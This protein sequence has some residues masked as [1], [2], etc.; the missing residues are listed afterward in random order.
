MSKHKGQRP[1]FNPPLPA[2]PSQPS[3]QTYETLP[4]GAVLVGDPGSMAPARPPYHTEEKSFTTRP[5]GPD[6]A[7]LMGQYINTYAIGTGASLLMVHH[8]P[9]NNS[10]LFI[11]ENP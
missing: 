8:I 4:D 7:T 10:F 9:A 11:W 6:T 3:R 1:T 5:G 2:L